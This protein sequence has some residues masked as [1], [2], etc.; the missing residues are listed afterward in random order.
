MSILL[1]HV[2]NCADLSCTVKHCASSKFILRHYESCLDI[3]CLICQPTRTDL[4]KNPLL[5]IP[6]FEAE[7]AEVDLLLRIQEDE[8][9]RAQKLKDEEKEKDEESKQPEQQAELQKKCDE[10][11]DKMFREESFVAIVSSVLGNTPAFLG[12]FTFASEDKIK[13][14]EREM[15]VFEWSRLLDEDSVTRSEMYTVYEAIFKDNP[16]YDN[17]LFRSDLGKSSMS[18]SLNRHLRHRRYGGTDWYNVTDRVISSSKIEERC[19]KI[20]PTEKVQLKEESGGNRLYRLQ[21]KEE[22]E[23]EEYQRDLRNIGVDGR[24]LT[25]VREMDDVEKVLIFQ[26]DLRNIGVDGRDLTAVREMDEV[27][28]VLIHFWWRYM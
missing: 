9:L 27:E 4:N 11:S 14:F 15:R 17:S 21:L 12:K 24:A 26:R 3:N 18:R 23:E 10:R 25:A 8:E 16:D 5:T 22:E 13:D 28:K 20:L 2:G 7:P 6:S 19:D 1:Y